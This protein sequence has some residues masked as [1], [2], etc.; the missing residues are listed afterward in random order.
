MKDKFQKSLL[1]HYKGDI[2]LA[3]EFIKELKDL[4][5]DISTEEVIN[6]IF[7]NPHHL[8]LLI[9]YSDLG[10]LKKIG[11]SITGLQNTIKK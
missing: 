8:T 1:R 10:L 9:T 6:E 3:K 5:L 11:E 7:N 4:G 2:K